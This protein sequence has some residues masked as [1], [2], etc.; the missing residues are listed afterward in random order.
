MR[1]NRVVEQTRAEGPGIRLCIWVQGCRHR[2]KGC[3]AKS[4]WD[5]EEGMEVDSLSLV[6]V[7][8]RNKDYIDG[9]TFLGGEP[10]DQACELL[11][12][13]KAAKNMGLSIIAFSGYLY[14]ELLKENGRNELLQYIDLLIDGPYEEEKQD[15]SRPLVG[16]SNQ[17][18]IYLTD[19]ISKCEIENY[20]NQIE[21]NIKANGKIE[22]NGMT[23]I[24]KLSEIILAL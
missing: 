8:R 7:I 4:T 14:E 18:F 5:R 20:R 23:D 16:S 9:I 15:F 1:I 19:Q 11:P 12:V 22:I 17:R 6:D 10:F 3:Y 21:L 24:K 13:A 2:C